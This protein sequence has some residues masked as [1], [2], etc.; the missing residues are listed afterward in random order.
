MEPLSCRNMTHR[1]TDHFSAKHR[2]QTYPKTKA[3]QNTQ[4]LVY[5]RTFIHLDFYFFKKLHFYP[6]PESSV[7]A[8]SSCNNVTAH[9]TS[10]INVTL[11]LKRVHSNKADFMTVLKMCSNLNRSKNGDRRACSGWE[12]NNQVQR[13]EYTLRKRDHSQDLPTGSQKHSR[14]VQRERGRGL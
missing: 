9:E 8:G 2:K 5:P 1:H 14:H 10:T 6:I 4:T 7:L 12:T 13:E 11:K 3:K